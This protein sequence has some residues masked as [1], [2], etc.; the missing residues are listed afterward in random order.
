M[1]G[2][3]KNAASTNSTRA[4]ATTAAP[5]AGASR[6]PFSNVTNQGPGASATGAPKANTIQDSSQPI[7]GVAP[8]T[9][10]GTVPG[11]GGAL[12]GTFE[13]AEAAWL[14]KTPAEKEEFYMATY[15]SRERMCD[16]F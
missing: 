9:A 12:S 2:L 15:G 6:A 3:S 5:K 16:V 4:N 1:S 10:Q 11:R 7:P 8:N 14:K 13:A